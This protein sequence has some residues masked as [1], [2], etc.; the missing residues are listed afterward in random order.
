MLIEQ[1]FH[2]FGQIKNSQT[3]GQLYSDTSPYGECSLT[4]VSLWPIKKHNRS[5]SWSFSGLLLSGIQ[6]SVDDDQCDQIWHNPIWLFLR[7]S[8][9]IGQT[10]EPTLAIFYE[11]G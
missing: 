9:S 3:R 4:Q 6:F 1:Q 11:I 5:R 2:L 10:F 8:Y 7:V